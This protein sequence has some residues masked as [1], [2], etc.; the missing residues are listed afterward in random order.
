[1]SAL[2]YIFL[3][4]FEISAALFADKI[5]KNKFQFKT[6]TIRIIFNTIGF[7]GPTL[8]M[9]CLMFVTK[10]FKFLGV[11]LITGGCAFL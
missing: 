3:W 4:A 5:L 10:E 9:I 2:P 8:A 11:A 6:K 1:M 7:F